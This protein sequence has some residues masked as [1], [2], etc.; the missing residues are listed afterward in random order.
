MRALF[1]WMGVGLML[2]GRLTEGVAQAAPARLAAINPAKGVGPAGQRPS[3]PASGSG[4]T[5]P[6]KNEQ[7]APDPI[8]NVEELESVYLEWVAA[9]EQR[10]DDA[11]MQSL[12]RI[13]TAP[14]SLLSTSQYFVS[15]VKLRQAAKNPDALRS[16]WRHA[17]DWWPSWETFATE[18]GVA[19]DSQNHP[20]T[21][22]ELSQFDAR[23]A[24]TMTSQD[25]RGFVEALEGYAR[26]AKWIPGYG[27][28]LSR[29]VPFGRFMSEPLWRRMNEA[30]LAFAQNLPAI[31]ASFGPKGQLWEA[32]ALLELKRNVEALEKI[33][34]VYR[35]LPNGDPVRRAA[36]KMW[37][38]VSSVAPDGPEVLAETRRFLEGGESLADRITWVA[39]YS[40]AM[41]QLPQYLEEHVKFL[42]EETAR[43]DFPAGTYTGQQLLARLD[44][45]RRQAP[46]D[47]KLTQELV[48]WLEKRDLGWLDRV[49]PKSLQDSR[50][51]AAGVLRF[52]ESA[53]AG[54][55][56]V[57]ILKYDALLVRDDK[58][59]RSVREN[60]FTAIVFFLGLACNDTDQLQ[61]LVKEAVTCESLSM[62]QRVLIAT[63]GWGQLITRFA[64]DEA[65][66]L[67]R[68]VPSGGLDAEQ[69]AACERAEKAVRIALERGKNW[70]QDAF[71]LVIQKQTSRA[72]LEIAMR[73]VMRMALAGQ[74]DEAEKMVNDAP[75][76][77]VDPNLNFP[78]AGVRLQW[79]RALSAARGMQPVVAA[80]RDQ[81]NAL[82]EARRDPPAAVRRHMEPR[83]TGRLTDKERFLMVADWLNSSK[84]E[85]GQL[86]PLIQA[87]YGSHQ[88]R[89]Y[90]K[91]GLDLLKSVLKSPADDPSKA[92]C[93]FASFWLADTYDESISRELEGMLRTFLDDPLTRSMMLSRQ[94]ALLTIARLRLR[95][96]KD[97]HPTAVFEEL[98]ASGLPSTERSPLQLTYLYNHKLDSEAKLSVQSIEMEA[99]V[100]P[101]SYPIARAVL[102]ESHRD[103][104][105]KLLDE[106]VRAKISNNAVILLLDRGN[107][108]EIIRTLALARA[109]NAGDLLSDVWFDHIKSNAASNTLREFL[110]GERA[111]LRGDWSSFEKSCET[112]IEA[113]SRSYGIYFD[114][115]TAAHHNGHDAKAQK[116]LEIFLKH[117]ADDSDYRPA[118]ELQAKLK[119]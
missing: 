40:D 118:L 9:L 77:D 29:L 44:T 78:A 73:I 26:M 14:I 71:A 5:A 45:L 11:A 41:S 106:A 33:K 60:A 10:R 95:Y 51:L 58:Q 21:D 7:A 16:Y 2:I 94:N 76:I 96:S 74:A 83:S 86:A 22:D 36:L 61:L 17:R 19:N 1:I 75:S 111:Y 103:S 12:R 70:G 62:E 31:D 84:V 4:S 79:L 64:P 99:L 52:P 92:V 56:P 6:E 30:F 65:A 63:N 98:N 15:L 3:A 114:L 104:Q 82:P 55:T 107:L 38:L 93:I 13:Q 85:P 90:P 35:Q 18:A 69:L 28:A 47:Q 50:F 37:L 88:L 54:F 112:Q 53:Q 49:S 24:A 116:A 119:N 108:D 97:P 48:G 117:G 110:D 101:L 109:A 43:A 39:L 46:D 27:E 8:S 113:K 89:S 100:N 20:P 81:V 66:T 25:V 105:L 59:P 32:T 23:M 68:L 115:A 87:L 42:A 34:A 91:F 102:L 57:E 67:L 80:L 72:H